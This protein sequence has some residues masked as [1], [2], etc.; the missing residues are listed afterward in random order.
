MRTK[1]ACTLAIASVYF[2]LTSRAFAGG[3][4]RQTLVVGLKDPVVLDVAV[5]RG[6]VRVTYSRD[7]EVG[8]GVSAH[9]GTGK[10][11]SD[12]FLRRGLTVKQDGSHI[13]VRSLTD[14][15]PGATP[16][17]FYQIDVPSR[18]EMK[19]SIFGTGNLTVIGIS[20]PAVLT[21][22]E[23]N[24]EVADVLRSRV[25]AR[26]GKGK[27]S[28]IKVREV[29]AETGSGNIVL[30][31]DGPS[32]AVVKKGLGMIEAAGARGSLAV[33]T[34]RGDVHVKAV[35]HDT[36][37]LTSVGGNIRIEMPP[38]TRF[39]LD[40]DTVSGGI[41]VEREDMQKPSSEVHEIHQQ[42]NGGG[43]RVSAHTTAGNILIQ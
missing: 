27:I 18:T 31:E 25:E 42:V 37:Q 21:T 28:C 32:R 7:G 43:S 26:T 20:G 39:N 12:E 2:A 9:D 3:P 17:I 19:A 38:K 14:L 6:D 13:Q 29:D 41:S 22:V 36:W 35:L 23:G 8:V 15:F 10:D 4:A 33:S 11:I 5:E 1:T 16:K 34:D 30:M 24:I 40:A